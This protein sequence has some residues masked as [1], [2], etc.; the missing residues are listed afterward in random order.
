VYQSCQEETLPVNVAPDFDSLTRQLGGSA[1]SSLVSIII[2]SSSHDRK[3]MV[4]TIRVTDATVAFRFFREAATYCRLSA[5]TVQVRATSALGSDNSSIRLLRSHPSTY[6]L[7]GTRQDHPIF[8]EPWAPVLDFVYFDKLRP[9]RSR[10]NKWAILAYLKG[11]GAGTVR[12]GFGNFANQV[13]IRTKFTPL[14]APCQDVPQRPIAV[15]DSMALSRYT[16]YLP[17][18]GSLVAHRL[19]CSSQSI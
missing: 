4:A 9:V 15:G 18:T 13:G 6:C 11:P 3:A 10:R 5:D 14:Q 12:R 2:G 19:S 8:I 1:A 17:T 7:V 16:S